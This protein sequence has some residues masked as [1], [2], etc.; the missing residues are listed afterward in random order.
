MKI[1]NPLLRL[2]FA[3]QLGESEEEKNLQIDM[4]RY[5]D[6]KLATTLGY[7]GMLC[8]IL[9]F[10]FI[11]STIKISDSDSINLLGITQ[12]G[13]LCGLDIF[14]NI[15]MLLFLFL[16]INQI[17]V[18]SKKWAFATIGLGAFQILRAFLY[19]LSLLNA[20]ILDGGLFTV[21]LIL[22]ILCGALLIFS[23]I[24]TVLL[25][26]TLENYLKTVKAIENERLAK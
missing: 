19:P 3:K 24:V 20:G 13:F 9:A 23:G 5:R 4:L 25:H 8:F 11:Y 14:I 21:V 7:I 12:S 10:C 26:N 15:I 2:I 16:A 18:Y 17:K 22:Y 6:N 1:K